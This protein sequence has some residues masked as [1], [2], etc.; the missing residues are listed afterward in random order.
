MNERN[1]S[2]THARDERLR[3]LLREADPAA[4]MEDLQPEEIAAMRRAMLNALR[5]ERSAFARRL[6]ALAAAA[7]AALALAGIL[8][9]RWNGS[10]GGEMQAAAPAATSPRGSR[11]PAVAPPP[12]AWRSTTGPDAPLLAQSPKAR[13]SLS[14]LDPTAAASTTLPDGI[15]RSRSAQRPSPRHRPSRSEGERL[16]RNATPPLAASAVEAAVRE[17]QFSTPGGTRIVWVFSQDDPS[18]SR[19][20]S[21]RPSRL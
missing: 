6:P 4:G 5:E 12:L 11:A 8:W 1:R 20:S 10:G 21:P 7:L 19:K 17:V 15:A 14:P 2:M 18:T 16:A 13:P 9:L 3:R